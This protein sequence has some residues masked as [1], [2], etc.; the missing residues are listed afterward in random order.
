MP[1][2]CRV[3]MRRP[4]G[5]R[6]SPPRIGRVVVGLRTRETE[7]YGMANANSSAGSPAPV[8]TTM[9]CLSLTI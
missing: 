7:L 3:L 6:F 9:Y 8:A 1:V 4:P 5:S 2:G